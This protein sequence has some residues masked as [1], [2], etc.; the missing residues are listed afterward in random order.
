MESPPLVRA[1]WRVRSW[2]QDPPDE[3][4]NNKLKNVILHALKKF[5]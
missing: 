5:L 3:F 4:N 2:V 1:R